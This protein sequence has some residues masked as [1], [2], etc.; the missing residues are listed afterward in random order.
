MDKQLN[1]SDKNL[2]RFSTQVVEAYIEI[3]FEKNT[4]KKK[5]LINIKHLTDYTER[6]EEQLKSP[7]KNSLP[8]WDCYQIILDDAKMLDWILMHNS[9]VFGR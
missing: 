5:K 2:I 4:L 6:V 9:S 1:Y 3:V 7:R 8:H